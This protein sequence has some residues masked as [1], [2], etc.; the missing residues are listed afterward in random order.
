LTDVAIQTLND[1]QIRTLIYQVRVKNVGEWYMAI[2]QHP[3]RSCSAT[4]ER[5]F[6][7]FVLNVNIDGEFHSIIGWGHPEL[8]FLLKKV[9]PNS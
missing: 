8:I 5:P 6:L 9:S 7:Q 3:L 4:D 2:Q 1:A